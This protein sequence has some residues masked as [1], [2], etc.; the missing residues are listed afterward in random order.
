MQNKPK[1]FL[2]IKIGLGEDGSVKVS[3]AAYVK[4][5]AEF[6]LR[7]P[8]AEYP[9]FESPSTPQLVKDYGWPLARST[10]WTPFSRTSISPR[11]AR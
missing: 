1:I 2:G 7:K 5:W 6:Y 4:A 3:A 9:R 8:L 10:T 11:L